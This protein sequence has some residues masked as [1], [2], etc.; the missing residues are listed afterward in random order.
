MTSLNNVLP[1]NAY[2]KFLR[3]LF[4][5]ELWER[6]SFYGM[7]AL[8]ILFLTT[9]LGFEDKDAYATYS[10]FTAL[11]YAGPIFGGLLADKLFGFRHMVVMGGVIIAIGHGLMSLNI[12]HHDLTFLGLA[13]IAVGT[14]LF[15]GNIANLLGDCYGVN[16]PDRVRGFT[17]FYVGVNV[18]AFASA[19]TCGYIGSYYGWHYGFGIAGIGMLTGL[20]LFINLQGVL[21]KA[22][23]APN[24]K[25]INKK[26]FP[27]ISVY[28][29]VL[30]GNII[31]AIT[32]A[33]MFKESKIFINILK[34]FGVITLIVLGYIIYKSTDQERKNLIKL[35]IFVFFLMA[36]FGVEMQIG[37]LI[38]LFTQ[39]NIDNLIFG[40]QIPASFSQAI[41]PLSIVIFG[42]IIGDM[43]RGSKK[44]ENIRLAFGIST[45]AIAFFILYFGCLGANEQGKVSYL[46]LI[47]SMSFMGIGEVCIGPLIFEKATLLSPKHLRGFIMGVVTLSLAFSNLAGIFIA[48]FMSVPSLDGQIDYI[49]SLAIYK[50]GFLHIA[51]TGLILV[52]T[53]FITIFLM[54]LIDGKSSSKVY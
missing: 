9:E 33:L 12:F 29:L 39:R 52:A 5:V 30:I 19:I 16:D 43:I 15:K 27:G 32:V 51:I 53:F 24:P 3:L 28:N 7:R 22:G 36:F 17:L 37:S 35:F 2:P 4:F 13:F 47:I 23:L 44:Y 1:L 20:I 42:F 10:L 8:L 38:N 26:L 46:Y 45:I 31:A 49:Q 11:S 18:G 41:N 40:M 48:Q 34:Y 50:E 25:L 54:K 21:G 14:G 6:F